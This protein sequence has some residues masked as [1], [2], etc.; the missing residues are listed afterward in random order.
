[1]RINLRVALAGLI[2][3]VAIGA[4]WSGLADAKPLAAVTAGGSLKSATLVIDYG[5]KSNRPIASFDLM[6]LP[7]GASGWDLFQAAGIAVQGTDQFP[8]GFVCRIDG[9]PNKSLQDCADTPA[10]DEGHWAYYVTNSSIGS[11]WVWSGQGAATH[12]PGCGGYEGWSWVAPGEDA[13]PPRFS[14]SP[15]ACK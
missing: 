3:L 8:S 12:I 7:T 5:T 9:W 11:G 1:M 6:D 15:R 2:A 10:F 14:I 13:K 4:V